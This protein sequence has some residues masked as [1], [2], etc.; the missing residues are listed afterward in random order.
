NKIGVSKG[1]SDEVQV[2]KGHGVYVIFITMGGNKNMQRK[3]QH[4]SCCNMQIHTSE[5]CSYGSN[6]TF[7]CHKKAEGLK[8]FDQRD[9]F[10]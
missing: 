7:S 10:I 6:S 1:Q 9:T 5:R 3:L 2:P 8:T 4:I